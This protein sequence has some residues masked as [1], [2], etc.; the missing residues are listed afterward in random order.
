MGS[1]GT[2]Q[3]CLG[4]IEVPDEARRKALI[5]QHER[6]LGQEK[7]ANDSA[8]KKV[9]DGAM[10]SVSPNDNRGQSQQS[11]LELGLCLSSD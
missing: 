4:L 10:L 2:G 8:S 7:P 5:E 3:N 11:R 6:L 1:N 9:L